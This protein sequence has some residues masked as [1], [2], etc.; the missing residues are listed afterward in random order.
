MKKRSDIYNF[1]FSFLEC[2]HIRGCL[3]S[4]DKIAGFGNT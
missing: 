3:F 4:L 1:P 2:I